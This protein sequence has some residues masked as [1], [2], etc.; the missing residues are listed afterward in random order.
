MACGKS[1]ETSRF[2]ETDKEYRDIAEQLKE[3]VR[4][5]KEAAAP[6]ECRE[7]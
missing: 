5:L 6:A 4:W 1:A 7:T 2:G 3:E